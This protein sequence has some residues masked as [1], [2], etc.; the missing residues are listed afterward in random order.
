M[1]YTIHTINYQ[2]RKGAI[3][4]YATRKKKKKKL[5]PD[6]IDR[7]VMKKEFKDKDKELKF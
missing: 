7:K 1:V 2:R 4:N 5:E 3:D 6:G